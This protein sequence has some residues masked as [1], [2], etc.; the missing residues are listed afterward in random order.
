MTQYSW[1]KRPNNNATADLILQTGIFYNLQSKTEDARKALENADEELQRRGS[2]YEELKNNLNT[3]LEKDK[4]LKK[5]SPDYRQKIDDLK[6]EYRHGMP[7]NIQTDIN[8]LFDILDCIQRRGERVGRRIDRLQSKISKYIKAEQ[9][10]RENEKHEM[11]WLKTK[12]NIDNNSATLDNLRHEFTE[13]LNTLQNIVIKTPQNIVIK[14]IPKLVLL[15]NTGN[16]RLNRTL[17]PN[18]K[19]ME[20]VK[21]AIEN[22][23]TP[24]RPLP[25]KPRAL[26]KE[27]RPLPPDPN[28]DD[29]KKKPRPF[30]KRSQPNGTGQQRSS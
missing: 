15:N 18:T 13:Y 24:L 25:K 19:D 26:L 3:L 29:T 14:N 30:P 6:Q 16:N 5:K 22:N 1:D 7:S 23:K 17:V 28:L 12:L 20:G 27:P 9:A 11:Q 4:K 8:S 10:L 21:Q 2:T